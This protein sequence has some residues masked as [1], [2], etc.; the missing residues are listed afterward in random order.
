MHEFLGANQV[1]SFNIQ[2]FTPILSHVNENEK[3]MAKVQNLNFHN[4]QNN[5]GRDPLYEYIWFLGTKSDGFFQ[6]TC[7]L[8][9]LQSYG[10]MLSKTKKK[11]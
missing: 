5:F 4:S 10:L 1:H 7:R 6:R 8:K 2:T 3:K 9:F 11:S